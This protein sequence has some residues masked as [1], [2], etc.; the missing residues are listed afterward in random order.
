MQLNI[1]NLDNACQDL[2]AHGDAMA[3]TFEGFFSILLKTR[4]RITN[5]RGNVSAA[6]D[7]D[8]SECAWLRTMSDG[9]TKV[10]S[11]PMTRLS[12]IAQMRDSLEQRL[13]HVGEGFDL[14]RSAP[15]AAQPRMASVLSAQAKSIA[16]TLQEISESAMR[17]CESLLEGL[18]TATDQI[19]RADEHQDLELGPAGAMLIDVAKSALETLSPDI[20]TI[21]DRISDLEMHAK[22]L[23]AAA[24]DMREITNASGEASAP[25]SLLASLQELYTSEV[26]HE[27]HQAELRRSNFH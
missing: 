22:D 7:T 26:E 17:S 19:P 8:V 1:E 18:E 12:S 20:Q 15:Q 3:K 21:A 11:L 4:S 24:A 16:D 5:V 2:L 27:I 9:L 25:A 14:L 10:T 23:G 6:V 13:A